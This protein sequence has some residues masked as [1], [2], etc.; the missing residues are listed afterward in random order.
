MAS[1]DINVCATP[2]GQAVTATIFFV[3]LVESTLRVVALAKV[4]GFSTACFKACSGLAKAV[5]RS[6]TAPCLPAAW[7]G[8]CSSNST[9]KSAFWL[10]T[11]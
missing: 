9:T 7:A 8:I 10:S 1:A 2:V 3:P 11:I 4:C 5:L 6:N